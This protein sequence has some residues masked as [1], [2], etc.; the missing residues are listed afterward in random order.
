MAKI[1]I[2][3]LLKG[4]VN[5]TVLLK[6]LMVKIPPILH[7]LHPV[8][9]MSLT[10][11]LTYY[12]RMGEKLDLKNPKDLNQKLQWLKINYRDSL[13]IQCADKYRVREYVAEKG[14]GN[15]LNELYAVYMSARDINFQSLPKRFVLKCNHASG[16]NIIC[17]DKTNLNKKETVKKLN[18]WLKVKNGFISGEY[19]YNHIVPLIIAEKNLASED[20]RLPRD[21]KVFCFNGEPRFLVV[22]SGKDSRTFI[23]ADRAVFDFDWTPLECVTDKYPSSPEKYPRPEKLEEIYQIA[24]GLSSG[25]PFVRVDFYVA[26]GRIVFGEMTFFPTGGFKKEFSKECLERFGDYLELPPRSQSRKWNDG[27]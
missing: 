16:T 4:V 1:P 20:G 9:P 13:Y 2:I 8:I 23:S 17:E 5:R 24:R 25:F 22:Y 3:L 21:Y 15:I 19:H 12:I 10:L 27:L 6:K 7:R 11:R 26:E 14:Y 18:K